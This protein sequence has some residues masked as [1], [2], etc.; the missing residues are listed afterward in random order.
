VHRIW[1]IGLNTYSQIASSECF[2]RRGLEA[3]SSIPLLG[4]DALSAEPATDILATGWSHGCCPAVASAKLPRT[5][6][7]SLVKRM[8]SAASIQKATPKVSANSV[9]PKL[10]RFA[11]S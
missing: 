7:P 8:I 6:S 5:K 11:S 2:K 4:G 3:V 1:Q 9:C 10:G